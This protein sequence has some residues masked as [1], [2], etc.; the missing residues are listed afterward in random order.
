MFA[1]LIGLLILVLLAAA[2]AS[3]LGAQ[4]G[5]LSLEWLGWQVE[6]R[7]SLAVALLVVLALLL[8][9]VD[10][11]LRGLLQLP[12]WLGRNL[13]R[14]RT[15]SGHRALAL[16]LMAV[17]AGEPDEARRQ[18]ARAQRLLSA[19]HLTDLLSA[20]AAHLSGDHKAAARYFT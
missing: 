8:L 6:M 18:A 14:R 19:P 3:W 13:A 16:G 7:T 15:D 12:S 1:R 20:Q 2:L 9:F 17:S 4:P 11:L 10:R 5:M